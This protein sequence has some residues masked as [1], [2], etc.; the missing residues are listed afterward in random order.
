M[1]AVE[2]RAMFVDVTAAL[3][4]DNRDLALVVIDHDDVIDDLRIDVQNRLVDELSDRRQTAEDVKAAFALLHINDHLERVADYAVT[5]GKMTLLL[6]GM[7]HD[8]LLFDDF[9]RMSQQ[10]DLMWQTALHSLQDRDAARAE[11]LLVLDQT[12][13]ELNRKVV[14]QLLDIGADNSLREWGLHMMMVFRCLERAGDHLVDVGEQVAYL[15]TGEMRQ[16]TDAST[17]ALGIDSAG[18]SGA[19]PRP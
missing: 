2:A 19:F 3:V 10:L 13:N 4:A 8:P 15:V 17:P 1:V 14:K 9:S 11:S 16:F 5:I 12:I 7:P 6:H 18:K